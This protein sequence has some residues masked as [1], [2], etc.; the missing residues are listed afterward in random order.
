MKEARAEIYKDVKGYAEKGD[1]DIM[2]PEDFLEILRAESFKIVG[3]YSMEVTKKAKSIIMQGMKDGVSEGAI[4]SLL[5]EELGDVTDKWLRTVVR[6][7]TTEI[8]NDSRKS[9]WDTDEIAA[10]VIV[11]YQFSAIL[12]SRTSD[13]CRELDGKIYEKGAFLDHVTPP[14][15]FNC[16][17]LLV[18]ITRFEPY[19]EDVNYVKPGKEPSLD[20][21][22]EMGGGLIVGGK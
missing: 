19:K 20:S 14:L 9:Y 1:E 12:D 7:K 10:Q 18:P 2:F 13:V 17:S 5:R 8:Y 4:V 15:H 3:D 11:A 16:R 6:T 21:L 22:R